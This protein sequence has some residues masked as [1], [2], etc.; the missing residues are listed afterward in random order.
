M[1]VKGAQA[2]WL[3]IGGRESRVGGE[4]KTA[5]GAHYC[6]SCGDFSRNFG[7]PIVNFLQT[8]SVQ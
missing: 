7:V 5:Y 6:L 2:V 4:E 3:G 1:R 8:F